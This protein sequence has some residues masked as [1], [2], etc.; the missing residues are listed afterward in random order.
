M[1]VSD[2]MFWRQVLVLLKKTYLVRRREIFVSIMEIIFP[3]V[4]TFLFNSNGINRKVPIFNTS[5][6]VF[7]TVKSS[8]FNYL[9]HLR[10]PVFPLNISR[11]YGANWIP[12]N[13]CGKSTG[14]W[15]WWFFPL[16]KFQSCVTLF[17]RTEFGGLRIRFHR[18]NSSWRFIFLEL[19]WCKILKALFWYLQSTSPYFAHSSQP[20]SCERNF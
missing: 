13:W 1:Q 20:T 15:F 10:S 19:R 2:L 11:A 8:S 16:V 14:R 4:L 3:V 18:S 9:V 5:I 12:I 6:G 7:E 17:S